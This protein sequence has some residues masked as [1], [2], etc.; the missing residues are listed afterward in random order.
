[1]SHAIRLTEENTTPTTRIK[2]ILP[3][4]ISYINVYAH[5]ETGACNGKFYDVFEIM[6]IIVLAI[7]GAI[8]FSLFNF[9]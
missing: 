8:P 1:M 7:Q 9:L 4:S 3:S 5:D 6:T 2:P